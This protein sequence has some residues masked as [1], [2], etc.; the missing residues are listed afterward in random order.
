MTRN[1]VAVGW[2]AMALVACGDDPRK[3]ALDN[4]AHDEELIKKASGAVSEVIRNTSDCDAAKALIPEAY[5][6]IQDAKQ[7]T[8]VPASQATLDALKVQ[9]DRVASA[10]P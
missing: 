1:I 10:C 7:Q 6:R 4:I 8:T 3:K 5:K 9:V 2:L